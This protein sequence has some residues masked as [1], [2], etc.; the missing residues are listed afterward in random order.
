MNPNHR[1]HRLFLTLAGLAAAALALPACQGPATAASHKA[2][3]H[4][5][6]AIVQQ[7]QTGLTFADLKDLAKVK[8][9]LLRR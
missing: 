6:Q 4:A 9:D 5:R 2:H 7:T 3:H 8:R 1:T